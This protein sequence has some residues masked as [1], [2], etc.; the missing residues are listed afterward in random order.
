MLASFLP[1]RLILLLRFP[2]FLNV[3]GG[4]D[5]FQ[6]TTRER[7]RFQKLVES[8]SLEKGDR[9]K[10][11]ALSFVFALVSSA[12]IPSSAERASLRSQF[13]A[14]GI[15]GALTTTLSFVDDPIVGMVEE[16]FSAQSASDAAAGEGSALDMNVPQDVVRRLE[17]SLAEEPEAFN[18]MRSIMHHLLLVSG[19]RSAESWQLIE[20]VLHAE[21]VGT[22]AGAGATSQSAQAQ[23][24]L[25]AA[26][27][28]NALN[29]LQQRENT[30]ADVTPDAPLEQQLSAAASKFAARA[31][32]G[33]T[34]A[35]T[36][37]AAATADGAAGASA[38][39]IAFDVSLAMSLVDQ[40]LSGNND[41]A[42]SLRTL[43]NN[44]GTF[45]NCSLTTLR[46]RL[47]RH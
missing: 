33:A 11:A 39:G 20:R 32:T 45:C 37:T 1:I 22:A 7:V 19:S 28:E 47:C 16:I 30:Q 10:V 6:L 40:V 17:K 21:I 46:R 23:C 14:L 3:L 35:T 36:T 25:N 34:A 43:L 44:G 31:A 5:H 29:L 24:R 9:Y 41:A 13:I 38:S 8:L 2:G 26:D 4:F 27:V 15:L 42:A 12:W 18:A